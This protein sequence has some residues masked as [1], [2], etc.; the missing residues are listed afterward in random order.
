MT[1]WL[2]DRANRRALERRDRRCRLPCTGAR[3]S[4]LARRSRTRPARAAAP[5]RIVHPPHRLVGDPDH[6]RAE[7][8][9]SA[10]KLIGRRRRAD[11][12]HPTGKRRVAMTCCSLRQPPTRPAAARSALA[13]DGTRRRDARRCANLRRKP[14]GT[15]HLAASPLQ[16][17]PLAEVDPAGPGRNATRNAVPGRATLCHRVPG[18]DQPR[19][20]LHCTLDPGKTWIASKPPFRGRTRGFVW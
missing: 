3:D 10:G 7:H 8:R 14:T 16:R 2:R 6:E 19:C 11:R 15:R 4:A 12:E 1:G 18:C 5:R 20:T 9:A 17:R 13:G